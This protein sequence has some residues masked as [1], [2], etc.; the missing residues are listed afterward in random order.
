MKTTTTT[1]TNTMIKV[2]ITHWSGRKE[3]IS[4]VDEW[5]INGVA[6]NGMAVTFIRGK[7]PF[8]SVSGIN[9][10]EVER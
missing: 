1:T 3:T 7:E 4:N 10:V 6:S 2:T 8:R 9:R 5:E